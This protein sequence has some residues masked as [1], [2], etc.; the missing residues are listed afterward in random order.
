VLPLSHDSHDYLFCGS[1]IVKITL[2][3]TNESQMRLNY[4]SC[5]ILAFRVG[6]KSNDLYF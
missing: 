1:G 6:S 5:G 3:H 2:S 4:R